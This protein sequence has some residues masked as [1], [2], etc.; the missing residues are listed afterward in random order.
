MLYWFQSTL[1]TD[2]L[3]EKNNLIRSKV[4]NFH[5]ER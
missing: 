5:G 4:M 2:A 1:A 3:L